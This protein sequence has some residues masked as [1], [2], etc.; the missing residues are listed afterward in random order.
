MG[1]D[2]TILLF[3]YPVSL[4]I[5]TQQILNI[6]PRINTNPSR[7]R[8]STPPPFIPTPIITAFHTTSSSTHKIVHPTTNPARHSLGT[9]I[10]PTPLLLNNM[11]SSLAY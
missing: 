8:S 11:I 2:S 10:A 9:T 3:F 6:L 5:Q 7:Q 1:V 4:P